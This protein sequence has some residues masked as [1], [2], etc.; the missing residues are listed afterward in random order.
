MTIYFH[1][2]LATSQ[3]TST[4]S[5]SGQIKFWFASAFKTIFD[6]LLAEST[7]EPKIIELHGDNGEVFW[8]IHDARTGKTI[9]CMTE[10][11][12]MEWLDARFYRQ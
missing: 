2:N 10:F 9:Y 4:Q 5:L 12:A 11:E 8:E 7:T 6:L 3:S 1:H